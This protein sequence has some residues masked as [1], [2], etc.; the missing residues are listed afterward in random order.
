MNYVHPAYSYSPKIDYSHLNT[1]PSCVL[2]FSDY[3]ANT[4]YWPVRKVTVG[5]DHFW[6]S[7]AGLESARAITVI[8]ADVHLDALTELIKQLAPKIPSTPIIFKLHPN[9]MLA[10]ANVRKSFADCSNVTVIA[11]E[12]SL[13]EVLVESQSVI[14]I[15]STGVYEALQMGRRVFILA[16]QD[17]L[18]HAD[19]LEDPL[20]KVVE[21]AGQIVAALEQPASQAQRPTYFEKFQPGVL[22]QVL[23][24]LAAMRVGP[25][26]ADDKKAA[27]HA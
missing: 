6:R 11:T 9:Q 8:S 26:P 27:T 15:H 12:K 10:A 23:A 17:Y 13:E 24:E 18:T 16:A 20:V 1:F 5:N 7:S 14:A 4:V 19:L 22:D 25:G 21:N 2:M 3:W